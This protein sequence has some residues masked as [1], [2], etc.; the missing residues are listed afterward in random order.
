[1]Y[2]TL[3]IAIAKYIDVPADPPKYRQEVEKAAIMLPFSA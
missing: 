1:M 2:Y 3:Y